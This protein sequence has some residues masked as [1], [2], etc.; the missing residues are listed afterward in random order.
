MIKASKDAAHISGCKILLLQA[1]L[2]INTLYPESTSGAFDSL[3][4]L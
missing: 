2:H 1:S 4:I 3:I